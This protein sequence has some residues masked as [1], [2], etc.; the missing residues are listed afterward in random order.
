MSY[1]P[2]SGSLPPWPRPGD[3]IRELA[4]LL[5]AHG[6]TG[7]YGTWCA[8]YGVLSLPA[9]LTVW[10]G[11]DGQLLSWRHGGMVMTWPAADTAGA[12]ERLADLL[13]GPEPR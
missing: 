1:R 5:R 11:L 8:A 10:F 2:A 6:V 12:A 4:G 9:D 3:V 7:L 13:S